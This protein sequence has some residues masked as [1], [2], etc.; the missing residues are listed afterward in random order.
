MSIRMHNCK[1][2]FMENS[3]RKDARRRAC[4]A[5][6]EIVRRQYKAFAF[7]ERL[8]QEVRMYY[9]N[10]LSQ[11]P[12]NSVPVRMKSRCVLTGRAQGVYRKFRMSRISFR[13]LALRGEILGVVKASW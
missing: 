3:I 11:C 10:L 6:Y 7:D 1:S 4:A 2:R 12:R 8:P 9:A 5:E 13:R